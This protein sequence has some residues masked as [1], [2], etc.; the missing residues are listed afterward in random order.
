MS[1]SRR[2]DTL[3]ALLSLA[4]ERLWFLDQ[5]QP[6]S[7]G[8]TNSFP[9][10]I[11]GRLNVP[12]LE[13]ALNEIV[14][15]HE[16]LRTHVV[17]ESGEPRQRISPFQHRPLAVADLRMV[18]QPEESA[19][20][21]MR[22][23]C[24]QTIRVQQ[25]PLFKWLLLRLTA[26]DHIIV[27]IV[28]HLLCDDSSVAIFMGELTALAKMFSAG[29]PSLLPDLPVQYGDYAEWYRTELRSPRMLQHLSYWKDQLR[30]F[31]PPVELPA[32]R[33]R[34]SGQ[35]RHAVKQI[36][37]PA[38]L[39]IGLEEFCRE[40]RVTPFMALLA[41]F[42]ILLW[43]YTGQEDLIVG[44][45]ILMRTQREIEGL[46]GLFL[47]LLPLRT[48][49]S[50]NPSYQ[51]ALRRVKDVA[52]AAYARADV[53]FERI[54]AEVQPPRDVDRNPLFDIV[55]QLVPG[56]DRERTA[57]A[58]ADVLDLERMKPGTPTSPADL[59]VSLIRRLHRFTVHVVYRT[60]LF[61]E[62]TITR[63]I[64]HYIVLLDRLIA[65]P[66]IPC[67]HIPFVS[68]AEQTFDSVPTTLGLSSAPIHQ[69]FEAR[70]SAR[71]DAW[72]VEMGEVRVTYGE[73]DQL[74]NRL[75]HALVTLGCGVE[76]RVALCLESGV[77]EIAA[78]L[79]TLKAGAAFISIDSM[80]PS[81]RLEL[82]IEDVPPTV[83]IGDTK[84]LAAHW[85][86]LSHSEGAAGSRVIV[87]DAQ[88]KDLEDAGLTQVVGRDYVD[89][90]PSV[91]L[92]LA[93]PASA[94]AYI[95]STSGST[96]RPKLVCQTHSAF[97]DFLGWFC[98]YFELRE[99]ERVAQWTQTTFDP[100]L[101]EIFSALTSG[102]TLCLAPFAMK[103]DPTRLVTWLDQCRASLLLTTP[104]AAAPA[105]DHLAGLEGPPLP[106][107]R[108]WLLAGEGIPVETVRRVFELFGDRVWLF[109]LYGPTEAVVATC[110]R[111]QP[112]DAERPVIPAGAPIEG[113]RVLV[114]TDHGQLCPIGVK[115]E[116]YIGGRFLTRGYLNRPE[117]TA[118]VFVSNPLS[119]RA[120]D[121]MYRTGDVGRWRAD[122]T[123]ELVGRMDSQVK[124]QGVRVELEEIEAVY[125]GLKGVRECAVI[126][127][128]GS[129][130][131]GQLIAYAATTADI[132]EAHARAFLRTKLP[133]YMVPTMHVFVEALPRLP[134]GKIDRRALASLGAPVSPDMPG[135]AVQAPQTRSEEIVQQVWQQIL[136][137]EHVGARDDFFELGG[138]S[139]LATQVV[140]R[141]E[142]IFAIPVPLRQ[143]FATP[144]VAGVSAYLDQHRTAERSGIEAVRPPITRPAVP[145]TRAPLSFGQ[146]RLWFLE[147]LHPHSA[148]YSAPLPLQLDGPVRLG[149][150]EAALNEIRRR[151]GI[152]RTRFVTDG[153][154]P[155]QV[156]DEYAPRRLPIVDLRG[157]RDADRLPLAR[158]LANA[159]ARRPLAF[160]A[161]VP[162]RVHLL[163]VG[164]RQHVLL[165]NQHH[166]VCDGWSGRILIGEL[167]ALTEAFSAGTP[168]LLPDVPVQYAD[169]AVWQREWLERAPLDRELSYWTSRLDGLPQLD[170]PTDRPRPAIETFRG[171]YYPL[172]FSGELTDALTRLG[173]HEGT[174]PFM[175]LLAAFKVLLCRYTGQEDVV[176]GAPI[177]N[178]TTNEV[179]PLIGFFLNTLVLRTDLSGNPTFLDLLKRVSETALGGYAHQELPFERLVEALQ[180]ARDLSRQ[181]LF[182][183]LLQLQN[184]PGQLSAHGTLTVRPIEVDPNTATYDLTLH[185]ALGSEGLRGGFI[186]NTDLFDAG[187]IARWGRQLQVL[188]SEIVATPEERIWRLSLLDSAERQQ[189]LTWGDRL[190]ITNAPELCLH[191]LFEAH[192]EAQPEAAA[193]NWEGVDESYRSLEARSNRVADALQALSVSPGAPVALLMDTGPGQ[194]AAILGVLKAGGILLGLDPQYPERR[195]RSMVAT[196]TPECLITE[197]ASAAAHSALVRSL[198]CT[199]PTLMLDDADEP[200]LRA[201]Y[202]P[203]CY[204]SALLAEAP[205]R[206]PVS[207]SPEAPAFMVFTSGSTGAPK[208]LL[209]SHRNFGQF[210]E[211]QGRSFAI[212]PLQRF[213]QWASIAYDA[214][215][216]ELLGALTCGATICLAPAKVRHDPET[217]LPW[218]SATGVTHLQ[219]V[220]SFAKEIERRLTHPS[221]QQAGVP[222]PALAYLLLAGEALP[223]T[224]ALSLGRL[225]PHVQ[226][227]NLY[228]PSEC[229]LAT[230]YPVIAPPPEVSTV[231]L[232][233]AFDGRHVLVLDRER[234]ACP[235]GVVGE[236]YIRSPHLVS[237]YLHRPEET[238][239]A[240]VESP[241][242]PGELL[243]RTGDFGRWDASGTLHFAGRRDQQ[244]K[245]RGVRIELGEVEAV[246]R[247]SPLVSD[248]AV[249][250]QEADGESR[251]TAYVVPAADR[252]LSGADSQDE[253][254][255]TDYVGRC[256]SV[257]DEIYAEDANYSPADPDINLRAWTSSYTNQPLAEAEIL[258]A[259]ED[260]V[261]RILARQPQRVLEIGSGTG[262]LL[263]RLAPSCIEILATDISATA[264]SRLR[265]RA[266][267]EPLLKHVR[268][269]RRAADDF[270]DLAPRS[271]D[272]VVLNLVTQHFPNADYLVRVLDRAAEV[273]RPGGFIFVGGIRALPLL[274]AFHTS[275]QLRQVPAPTSSEHIRQ[276]IRDSVSL[277]KDLVIDPGLFVA[278]HASCSLI[279]GLVIELKGGRWDNEITRHQ[280]DVVLTVGCERAN[281]VAVT[282]R[283]WPRNGLTVEEL[284]AWL[285][286]ASGDVLRLRQVPNVRVQ[287]DAQAVALL[288]VEDG[289]TTVGELRKILRVTPDA[290]LHPA[291]LWGLRD[292]L[293][294]DVFVTWSADDVASMDVVFVRRGTVPPAVVA[295]DI[296]PDTSRAWDRFTNDPLQ[297][298][299][300]GEL[301]T[302]LRQVAR[303]TL[304]EPAV[305]SAFV[306][307]DA[308]PRT[309]TGKVDRGAL[310]LRSL[311]P[312]RTR[313]K[314]APPV[315]MT[316]VRVSELWKEV[317]QV[318]DVGRDE[319][320]FSL[321][322]HS[323]LAT[324]ILNRAQRVYN[325]DVTLRAFLGAPTVAAL[326]EAIDRALEHAS[327][328]LTPDPDLVHY[329]DGAIS[330]V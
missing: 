190:A 250:C 47:N 304:A 26:E 100:A 204:G 181:P 158:S 151:H 68:E 54:V 307:L 292:T 249:V 111:V 258:E 306:L 237:G 18:D 112:K 270:S 105:L 160:S 219:V 43:R 130:G 284:T 25:P 257:Y 144:T 129:R 242:T 34:S 42:K 119:G 196:A 260:T 149:P 52:V 114:L 297:G 312:L 265:A 207:V 316:E 10:R 272:A 200:A 240:F 48:S 268:I 248:V 155:K 287:R 21:I 202:G 82:I 228:G 89:R 38:P 5:F 285:E 2:A 319:S 233:T 3:S 23:V 222:L 315:T 152:L 88:S 241:L 64:E 210:L 60:D 324:Q 27:L 188:L 77:E 274:E 194:V 4:Q 330:R 294:Y 106:S 216:C 84:S 267:A 286:Q 208:G 92:D 76:E 102:A 197:R 131:D 247:S 63:L 205:A 66:D 22:A 157:L 117:E 20:G 71:P 231:P 229:V 50:G 65:N 201:T 192:A 291:D 177:A 61:D 140:N 19:F 283:E 213:A 146:Q 137:C 115:G 80:Q 95:A 276:R 317:L 96:G 124:I 212:R 86:W 310:S 289:P 259:V 35:A 303:E 29:Q 109:N 327:A 99:G 172:R 159:D 153:Q 271:F 85:T 232:G 74:S 31:P 39:S 280:Y 211:W 244:I 79:A 256:Q 164:P 176:V 311:G 59:Q 279:S 11:R 305:P 16:I 169:F 221:W 53:P 251:L 238:A 322:G 171:A 293:D 91:R 116:I 227:F 14:R 55:F 58:D 87:V 40:R 209:Q 300:H 246:L 243:Y 125:A 301:T 154:I 128:K 142:R 263:F 298:L 90:Q 103:R 165:L 37:L 266:A 252:A 273:V 94:T 203:R 321:G 113:C 288:A 325:V 134:G 218:L 320:F 28:S 308:L 136:H 101:A 323:L 13:H 328:S 261:S 133:P 224:L 329:P 57:I 156:I 175:T 182:Q 215:Y 62:A 264:V 56:E 195:L 150:L 254:L 81:A 234:M 168:S 118:R 179:E 225:L 12:S 269:E 223:T 318:S 36:D 126:Y 278:F 49:I 30:D 9:L 189:V 174:T 107:L 184:A 326:A 161:G 277:D 121:L 214:S 122:G 166:L 193:I 183:T 255:A 163:Q 70:A 46:I 78:M 167:M 178:R 314:P 185:L 220:P 173:Q 275:A 75:A 45:P 73:L 236:I 110:H 1:I 120:D 141:L 235:T 217:L 33:P 8:L 313:A 41:A 24:S 132:T 69:L 108:Q 180:P 143:M 145:L 295:P 67:G 230:C 97:G 93:V 6:D 17:V 139:L 51:E 127:K 299:R 281:P 162:F 187:T 245:V 83:I 253:V 198:A 282:D 7:L 302:K 138:H 135:S 262:L 44:M 104:G 191:Q 170:L 148:L 309:A 123:I 290:G 32:D 296:A 239:A 226:M 98:G 186:Y 199:K 206:T 15:R 147:Q 72:A